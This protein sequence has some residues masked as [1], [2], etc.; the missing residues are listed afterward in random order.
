MRFSPCADSPNRF[1]TVRESNP[2]STQYTN[3]IHT[4]YM[5]KALSKSQL[6]AELAEKSGLTKKAGAELLD[7]LATLAYKHAKN[8]FT[9]HGIRKHAL[10]NH[11]ALLGRNGATDA[12]LHIP[13]KKV[14]KFRPPK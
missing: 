6:A 3:P 11:H 5:A 7:T 13:A 9:L 4:H 10:V 2:F 1:N 14:V 12:T 8:C